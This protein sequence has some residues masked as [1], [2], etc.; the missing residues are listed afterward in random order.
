MADDE[1]LYVVALDSSIDGSGFV[2]TISA[3]N[4]TKK[5]LVQLTSKVDGNGSVRTYQDNVRELVRLGATDSGGFISVY[6]KM[7]EDIATM[8][9]D[10]YGNGVVGAWNRKGKGRT[11]KPGP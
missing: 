6:N 3:K 2:E 11:L 5:R 9:A 7:G 8:Y 4:G 10:E 1:G